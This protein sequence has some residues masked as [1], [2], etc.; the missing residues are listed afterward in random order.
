MGELF[1]SA[2]THLL[3]EL[4]MK[5][6]ERHISA[7]TPEAVV[8][9]PTAAEDHEDL[10]CRLNN[11]MAVK[12]EDLSKITAPIKRKT[13]RVEAMPQPDVDMFIKR[14]LLSLDEETTY[15]ITFTTKNPSKAQK[16]A[17]RL[18]KKNIDEALS[19]CVRCFKEGYL[20]RGTNPRG[21]IVVTK[22]AGAVLESSPKSDVA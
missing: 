8:A 7:E 21:D 22:K 20:T 16:T 4:F 15:V 17:R 9:E 11:V 13:I 2:P 6:I 10:S 18:T 19:K 5:E 14:C 12:Q 1:P 3:D